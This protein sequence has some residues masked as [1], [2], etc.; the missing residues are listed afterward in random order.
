MTASYRYADNALFPF[1]GDGWVGAGMERVL[2]AANGGTYNFGFTSEIRYWFEYG[3]GEE[4][5]F[6]GDDDLWVFIN[7]FLAV[8]VGGLH[9]EQPGSVTLT[10]PTAVDLN[11]EVGN[12][13]E[14]SLFHAE[15]RTDE[16]NFDLTLAGFVQ[17]TSVC[18]T[19]CG[20][21]IVTRNEACDDGI[22]DGSYGGCNPDC[23]RGPICG[24]G[25]LDV[26]QEACD[27][28]NRRNGD[29]CSATCAI[30]VVR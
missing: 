15:R 25:R 19:I 5:D 28:G 17:E 24:D 30:E 10:G 11:L 7:G 1:D 20:D 21:G 2:D 27:D 3:G 22:N 6:F 4:L 26:P 13:Y 16:S 8:D 9:S 18:K 29:G 23:S 12:L 14:I